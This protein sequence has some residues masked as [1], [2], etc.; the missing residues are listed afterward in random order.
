MGLLRDYTFVCRYPA[1]I[2]L[3]VSTMTRPQ[4]PRAIMGILVRVV[5]FT[6]EEAIIMKNN[7]AFVR[8]KPGIIRCIGCKQLQTGITVEMN[9]MSAAM[10]INIISIK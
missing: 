9:T 1:K 10:A 8:I 4:N 7:I 5:L 3:N 2:M 6:K